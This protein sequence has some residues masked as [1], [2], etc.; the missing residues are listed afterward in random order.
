MKLISTVS[1]TLYLSPC[2]EK[3]YRVNMYINTYY[4]VLQECK[5][6]CSYDYIQDEASGFRFLPNIPDGHYEFDFGN[7]EPFWEPASVE[8]ELKEQLKDII[9]SEDNLT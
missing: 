7:E 2:L 4:S 1:L 3:C 9:L 6:S 8:E 5:S